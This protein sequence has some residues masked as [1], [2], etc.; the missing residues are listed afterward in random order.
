MLIITACRNLSEYLDTNQYRLRFMSRP[1]QSLRKS[2]H[3]ALVV[4]I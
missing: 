2:D 1:T 3:L 4:D